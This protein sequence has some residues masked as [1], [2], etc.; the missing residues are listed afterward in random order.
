MPL[1]KPVI[2]ILALYYAVGHWNAYFGAM[3]YLSDR[4]FFPLQLFLREIL[5]QEK[6]SLEMAES[7]ES[8]YIAHQQRIAEMVKYSTMI[9]SALPLLIVYPFLQ[10]FF[11]KGVMIGSVKG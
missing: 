3:I 6:M 7:V 11:V 4:K 1:S 2:A 10:R 5:I 8:D 9:V